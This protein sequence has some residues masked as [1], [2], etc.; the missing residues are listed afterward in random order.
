M[1]R[2]RNVILKNL[3]ILTGGHFCLLAT[4]VDNMTIDNVKMDTN[5]D[6]FDIDCCRHVRMS[7][8]SVN[9]PFDDAIVLKSSYALGFAR[10]TEN[11]TITNCSVSGFDI[12][13]F[14]NGTYKGENAGMDPDRGVVIGRIK[15]G[16]ESNGGFRNITASNCTFEF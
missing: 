12:G 16:T 14:L 3:A 9:S 11:V 13:T 6:G 1:K 5:R 15:F 8:C 7:N 2:C 10:L 4:G